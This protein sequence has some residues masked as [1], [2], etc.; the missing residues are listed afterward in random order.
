MKFSLKKAIDIALIG[1]FTIDLLAVCKIIPLTGKRQY[2]MIWMWLIFLGITIFFS[3]IEQI[4]SWS[5]KKRCIIVIAW[6][7]IF[8]FS[9]V[10]YKITAFNIEGNTSVITAHASDGE[11]KM[12]REEPVM[13]QVREILNYRGLKRTVFT[14]KEIIDENIKRIELHFI[15]DKKERI[16]TL[17]QNGR[18]LFENEDY[19]IGF[20]GKGKERDLF[21]EME[22]YIEQFFGEESGSHLLAIYEDG[23][24]IFDNREY[25]NIPSAKEGKQLY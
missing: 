4:Q 3:Q 23:T 13:S 15:Y 6:G 2:E 12:T 21:L 24:V 17:Y 1:I 10:V 7:S 8:L 11:I 14:K 16:L 5:W 18:I 25:A 9:F 22:W 20:F 19:H